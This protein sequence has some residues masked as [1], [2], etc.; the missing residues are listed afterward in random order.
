LNS[1][2][3]LGDDSIIFIDE[4][5]KEVD[6]EG[7]KAENDRTNALKAISQIAVSLGKNLGQNYS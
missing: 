6:I 5:N 7:D 4:N 1:S 3:K 2:G